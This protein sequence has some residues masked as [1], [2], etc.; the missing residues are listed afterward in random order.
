[1]LREL[2]SSGSATFD[3]VWSFLIIFCVIG[4]LF[5]IHMKNQKEKRE[6]LDMT[7]IVTIAY[8]IIVAFFEMAGQ[9]IGSTTIGQ[10]TSP[11]DI[12]AF[13]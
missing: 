13:L 6:A 3:A 12:L 2:V 8:V 11:L 4:I 10:K 1:M 7:V 9:L 5:G